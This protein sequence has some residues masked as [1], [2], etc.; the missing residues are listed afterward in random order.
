MINGKIYKLTNNQND[1]YYIGSTK[2]T[3]RNRLYKHRQD[4]RLGI[5][6]NNKLHKAINDIGCFCWEITLIIED[7]FEDSIAMRKEEN[8]YI[9]L[10]DSKILNVKMAWSPINSHNNTSKEVYEHIKSTPRLLNKEKERAKTRWERLKSD[11]IA[12]EQYK[13]K[14]REY[15][16][17]RYREKKQK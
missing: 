6:P 12:Y 9:N 13:Q 16:K 15:E 2:Q 7:N 3:L 8:K 1:L 10:S 4:A 11:P 17:K 5:R 14:R